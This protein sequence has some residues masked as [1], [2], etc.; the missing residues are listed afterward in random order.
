MSTSPGSA[1]AAAVAKKPVS[2]AGAEMAVAV[3]KQ[4]GKRLEALRL[5]HGARSG[6]PD[7]D[8]MGMAALLEIEPERYRRYERGETEPPI[9]LLEKICRV[10][11]VSVDRL[12]GP[13]A[14]VKVEGR[15][16]SELVA[17]VA[18]RLRAARA[19]M[20]EHV[21]TDLHFAKLCDAS[22]QDFGDWLDGKTLPG[23]H[24]MT[25]LCERTGLCL[26]WIYRG[27]YSGLKKGIA[28]RLR[29]IL[30]GVDL[31]IVDEEPAPAGLLT[32]QVQLQEKAEKGASR[33]Q[34]VP[35]AAS[36]R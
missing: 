22:V 2:P 35:A 4:F 24:S 15:V 36:R 33:G 10:A 3:R 11:G 26:D 14:S 29:A 19:A 17:A 30:E 32:S 28:I 20:A 8:M 27:D 7:L 21:K 6:R 25:L 23:P 5:Y 12:I 13:Q 16:S 18:K 34:Q 9:W 31:A 1:K